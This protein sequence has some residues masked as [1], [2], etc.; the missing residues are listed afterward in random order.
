L[1][2]F[3]TLLSKEQHQALNDLSQKCSI[4]EYSLGSIEVLVA[5]ITERLRDE[6]EKKES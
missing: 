6:G 1:S 3:I 5:K 4:M 2:Q